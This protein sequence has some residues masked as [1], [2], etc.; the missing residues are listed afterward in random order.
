M[1]VIGHG[2]PMFYLPR[3]TPL[4]LPLPC[5]DPQALPSASPFSTAPQF[6][7]IAPREKTS[8]LPCGTQPAT[9]FRAGAY[10]GPG[11]GEG[12]ESGEASAG[13]CWVPT[14]A[15]PTL[16][17]Y[18]A[19]AESRARCSPPLLAPLQPPRPQAPEGAQAPGLPSRGLSRGPGRE[20]L[21]QNILFF[22]LKRQIISIFKQFQYV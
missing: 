16:P 9:P 22:Y 2:H 11:W 18:A 5:T 13:H 3:N 6:T 20:I 10:V 17:H 19:G 15:H 7:A 14:P 1:T 8:Q 4:T 21:L 12:P